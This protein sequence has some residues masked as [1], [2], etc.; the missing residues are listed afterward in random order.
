MNSRIM[1]QKHRQQQHSFWKE[2]SSNAYIGEREPVHRFQGV[3]KSHDDDE[4]QSAI[5]SDV[6]ME[7]KAQAAPATLIAE[8][9]EQLEH[10]MLIRQNVFV[11]EQGIANAFDFWDAEDGKP[12]L[13]QDVYHAVAYHR[14]DTSLPV[15]TGRMTV[16]RVGITREGIVS[17]VAVLKEYRG[18]GYARSIMELLHQKAEELSLRATSLHSQA[19]AIGFYQSMGYR[20][21][22]M[23]YREP[24]DGPNGIL[25]YMTKRW[26]QGVQDVGVIYK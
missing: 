26:P 16:Q 18:Q 12:G 7:L 17:N 2:W 4:L 19:H 6:D 9:L 8:S 11:E 25:A 10:A 13:R 20:T 22:K 23:I 1:R 21:Q 3:V 24:L 15:G 14:N 5:S